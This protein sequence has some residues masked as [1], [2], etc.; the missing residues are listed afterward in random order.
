[1]NF[2]PKK[3]TPALSCTSA[4]DKQTSSCISIY[5]FRFPVFFAGDGD[6]PERVRPGGAGGTGGGAVLRAGKGHCR[7]Y[8][9][10]TVY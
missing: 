6:R 8:V 4:V 1:M 9:V 10:R 3:K 7:R 2:F 5:F